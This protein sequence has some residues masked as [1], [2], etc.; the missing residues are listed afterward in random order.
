MA[1]DRFLERVRPI[2]EEE[3]GD[4][5]GV[6][7]G[8]QFGD[9]GEEGFDACVVSGNFADPLE[10]LDA[11][12]GMH[13]HVRDLIQGAIE[14]ATRTV[15][16][17]YI[18]KVAGEDSTVEHAV[19]ELNRAFGLELTAENFIPAG[20]DGWQLDEAAS[21]ALADAYERGD[22]PIMSDPDSKVY[23]NLTEEQVK[24]VMSGDAPVESLDE[25]ETAG[26]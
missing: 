19:E 15:P 18:K 8:G 21:Q 12:H 13:D 22:A 20:E 7:L 25:A 26:E 17:A 11:I 14:A 5:A 4:E 6:V 9:L 10:L 23:K 1:W 16:V 2:A 24:A 3:L